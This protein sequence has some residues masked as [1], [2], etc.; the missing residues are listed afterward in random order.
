MWMKKCGIWQR[1][2]QPEGNSLR[3]SCNNR[4]QTG[5]YRT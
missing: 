2:W 4:F 3:I 5:N 1:P